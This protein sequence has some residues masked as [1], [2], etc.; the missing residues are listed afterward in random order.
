MLSALAFQVALGGVS[1]YDVLWGA[2]FGFATLNIL[3]LLARRFEPG[4]TRMTLG[5]VLAIT[6]AVVSL[7][8]LG[9]ELLFTFH[10]LP[11]HLDPH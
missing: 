8:M 10:V 11:I 2:V 5:E 1:V 3:G 4:R 6:A 7:L 9:W